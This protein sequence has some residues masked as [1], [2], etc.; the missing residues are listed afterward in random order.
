MNIYEL[1][2]TKR[3]E[4]LYTATKYGAYNVRIFGSVARQDAD[5]Q[6]DIDFLVEMQAD[7]SLFDLGGLLMELQELLGRD[8]DI[9]TEKGLRKRIR[10]RVLK[11]AS[12]NQP[13]LAAALTQ[14]LDI[15]EKLPTNAL[16][17]TNYGICATLNNRLVVKAPDWSYIPSIKVPREEV[18]RSYTPR[19]QGDI[20]IIVME[21]LSDTE[22]G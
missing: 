16:T 14:S 18:K 15:A 6:S 5:A 3:E 4:I 13:I 21:F 11:E 19:L 8:V 12:I 9:V 22:G 2:R 1:L 17:T 20:P 10:E 7:K